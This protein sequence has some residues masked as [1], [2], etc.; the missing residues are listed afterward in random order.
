M[1]SVK[2]LVIGSNSFSGS[3]LLLSLRAGHQLW[4]VGRSEELN[5]VF[6]SLV[7]C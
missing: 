6:I 7:W 2:I 3:H 5:S 4:G 1:K